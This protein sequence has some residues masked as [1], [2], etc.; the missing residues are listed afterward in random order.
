MIEN[1]KNDI[2]SS[3][4]TSTKKSGLFEMNTSYHSNKSSDTKNK[5][6]KDK[7]KNFVF[8]YDTGIN[9]TQNSNTNHKTREVNNISLIKNYKPDNFVMP[10]KTNSHQRLCVSNYKSQDTEV[11]LTSKP[12]NI[13]SINALNFDSSTKETRPR[14]ESNFKFVIFLIN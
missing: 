11:K 7:I 10:P 12:L 1:K 14:K 9:L 2:L 13:L 6:I 4:S 3:L 5:S 8:E